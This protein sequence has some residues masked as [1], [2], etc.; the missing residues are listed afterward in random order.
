MSSGGHEVDEVEFWMAV[1]VIVCGDARER[2]ATVIV[3][4]G[5]LTVPPPPKKGPFAAAATATAAV[6]P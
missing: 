1:V 2:D 6:D 4:G 5:P 3:S